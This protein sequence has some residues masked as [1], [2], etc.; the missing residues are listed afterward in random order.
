MLLLISRILLTDFSRTLNFKR[1]VITCVFIQFLV[2][3]MNNA[4]DDWIKKISVMGNEYERTTVI[5]EPTF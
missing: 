5:G 1:G 3:N 4:V 2:L